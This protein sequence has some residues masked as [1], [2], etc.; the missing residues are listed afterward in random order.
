MCSSAPGPCRQ[1]PS[2]QQGGTA[3]AKAAA[4]A[5]QKP[6][7]G[8][9]TGPSQGGDSG[10]PRGGWPG[11]NATTTEEL[12]SPMGDSAFVASKLLAK[13]NELAGKTV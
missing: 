2:P 11:F 9:R 13:A 7:G 3:A 12:G 10:G 1:T 5:A 4:A 8:R 6:P